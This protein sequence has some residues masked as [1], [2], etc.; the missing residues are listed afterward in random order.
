MNRLPEKVRKR[1]VCIV[2]P[3]QKGRGK[4]LGQGEQGKEA[5][6]L[7][8]A[9]ECRT[10]GKNTALKAMGKL[11]KPV[12]GQ[13]LRYLAMQLDLVPRLLSDLSARSL[14]RGLPLFESTS[15]KYPDGDVSSLNEEH[16]C[17]FLIK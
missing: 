8:L 15:G 11:R 14:L 1:L 12:H 13:V 9:A 6:L 5:N 16:F 7:R 10:P 17:S 4:E 3:V 2:D